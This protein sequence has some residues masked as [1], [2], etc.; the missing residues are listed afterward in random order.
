MSNR[1]R[2]LVMILA[3][4]G[5]YYGAAKLGL[6]LAFETPSVTAIWAPTGISL[7]ALVLFGVRLWP[8]VALG[9][10]L[11]NLGT[12]VPLLPVLGIT[13]GNTLE[14]LVGAYLLV[15]VASFR[16]SLERAFDVVCLVVLGAF[17]S[18]TVSATIGTASLLA[19][20]EI[21]GEA[22]GSTWRTWWLGDMGG[23][24]VVAPALLVAF[25]HRPYRLVRGRPG[26]GRR[27]GRAGRRHRAVR[28][29]PRAAAHVPVGAAA[30]ARRV[31][32]PAAGRRGREPR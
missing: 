9:A 21:D 5:A 29:Y 28:L 26:R 22:F 6:S 23:D 11:A 27:A 13:A 25:T 8:G 15:S 24:L 10:F 16:P 32:V 18:T 1:N 30:V 4:A 3:L 31:P 14:A 2:Y 17:V 12:G 7:A 19:G 20:G